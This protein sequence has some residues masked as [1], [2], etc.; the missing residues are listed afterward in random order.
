MGSY[1]PFWTDIFM[2]SSLKM[3]K[4]VKYTITSMSEEGEEHILFWV[5]TAKSSGQPIPDGQSKGKV[6]TCSLLG[7][8]CT[9]TY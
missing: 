4:Y 2:L 6:K 9:P 5:K 3:M 7:K 1:Y 8:R